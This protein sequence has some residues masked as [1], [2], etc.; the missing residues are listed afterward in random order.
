MFS[1]I[2]TSEKPDGYA[3]SPSSL[4]SARLSKYSF[5]ILL[6]NSAVSEV[7]FTFSL[8]IISKVLFKILIV[9]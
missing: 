6:K 1:I 4:S 9:S 7:I 8:F 3:G 2:L 5:T